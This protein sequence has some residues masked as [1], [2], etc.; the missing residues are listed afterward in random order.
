ME[1]AKALVL[2]GRERHDLPWPSVRSVPKPLVPVANRPIL[3]H[4]L[5]ALRSAGILEA[6]IVVEPES[7]SAIRCAAGDGA[8]WGLT[9]RYTECP[10]G[11]G[12]DAA[13]AR[14]RTFLAREPVLV[15]R[16]GA[17]LRDR[18][19]THIAVFAGER[20]DALALRLPDASSAALDSSWLLSERAVSI[21]ATHATDDPLSCVRAGGGNVRVEEVDGCLP[22][23][24]G[25]ETLLEANRRMLE[26]IAPS[27]PADC[28]D[29]SRVQG[30]VLVH[31]TARLVRSL[32]RGPA[33]IGPG[34]Q[35]VDAYVGP[36]SSIG[37]DA[38]VEGTEIEYSI[39][40]PRAELRHLGA[41]LEASVI[42]H[43]ARVTRSFS[44]PHALRLSIG[45]GAEVTL[46]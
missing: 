15:Q 37:A 18:I 2:T 19:H 6:T 8:E 29:D 38:V 32:V 31:P 22:C 43:R 45:D 35:L 12:V 17:L 13:L 16:V 26:Q 3:F 10:G 40:L 46:S 36:Y 24:G 39:V 25:Q 21:L 9:L 30:P 4:N 20:L 27:I 33:V 44:V 42:G 41:R 1:I 23:L 5:D 11:T 7:A 34:A 28:L 14:A